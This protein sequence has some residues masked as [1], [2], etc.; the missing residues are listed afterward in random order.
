MRKFG[1]TY[2]GKNEEDLCLG[3]ICD[4]HFRAVDDPVVSLFFRPRLQRE[5][6]GSRGS[7]REAE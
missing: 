3:R 1:S 5:G 2:V 6:V 7:F 4:P